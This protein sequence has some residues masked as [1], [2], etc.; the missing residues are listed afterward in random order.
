MSEPN[1]N[2][3]ERFLP[4]DGNVVLAMD[5]GGTVQRLKYD[6]GRWFIVDRLGRSVMYV[7][8]TPTHWAAISSSQALDTT[9][10][11]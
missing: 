3:T 6:R 8:Y 7:Y 11:R 5:S 1:W 9:G 10:E 4:A 2:A